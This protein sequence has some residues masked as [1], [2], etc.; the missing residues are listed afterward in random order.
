MVVGVEF[1]PD[2]GKHK[3]LM[4]FVKYEF[5]PEKAASADTMLSVAFPIPTSG[6]TDKNELRYNSTDLGE[7]KNKRESL[8]RRC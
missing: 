3:F 8:L 4:Q 2:L 5:D 7:R 1:P 6:M